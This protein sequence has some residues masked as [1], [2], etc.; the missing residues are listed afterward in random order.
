M[1]EKNRNK[2]FSLLVFLGGGLT[3]GVLRV[4]LLKV[5]IKKVK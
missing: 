3:A 1:P 2:A 4:P 5:Y